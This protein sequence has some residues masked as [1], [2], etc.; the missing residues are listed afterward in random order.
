MLHRV[1]RKQ[2][3]FKQH[4]C[5]IWTLWPTISVLY[6]G[7][8]AKEPPAWQLKALTGNDV[9]ICE[10]IEGLG[11]TL[12]KKASAWSPISDSGWLCKHVL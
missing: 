9:N 4:D 7:L 11:L 1:S 2:A 8:F 12:T 6:A 10:L 5:L 3:S